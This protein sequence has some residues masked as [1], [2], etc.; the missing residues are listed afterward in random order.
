VRLYA[1]GGGGP[2]GGGYHLYRQRRKIKFNPL[3]ARD[4]DRAL[5]LEERATGGLGIY[6]VKKSMDGLSY[7]Y[8]DGQ[9]I[10]RLRKNLGLRR[11]KAC[12]CFA[13]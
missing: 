10:L 5:P 6:M 11:E 7:E 2:A 1:D 8:R 9:N 12:A 3:A 13:S 4:P